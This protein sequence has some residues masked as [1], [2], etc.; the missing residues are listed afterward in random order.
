MRLSDNGLNAQLVRHVTP[1]ATAGAACWA[2]CGAAFWSL[3]HKRQ[4]RARIHA[5]HEQVECGPGAAINPDGDV[6]GGKFEAVSK[7]A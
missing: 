5:D 7:S 2:T 6:A 1:S 3:L 4:L